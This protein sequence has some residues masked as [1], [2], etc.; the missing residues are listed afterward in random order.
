MK[1]LLGLSI[2]LAV[3][4]S[5]EQSF[6]QQ[7]FLLEYSSFSANQMPIWFAEGEGLFNVL[8]SSRI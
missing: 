5:A 8:A 7:R 3:V 1:L 6:A 4:V 2:F